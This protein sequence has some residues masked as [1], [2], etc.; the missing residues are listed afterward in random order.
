ML[1]CVFSVQ[2]DFS[3]EE[4]WFCDSE[5]EDCEEF[6]AY[7]DKLE[8]SCEGMWEAEDDEDL[9]EQITEKTNYCVFRIE[10]QNQ[11]PN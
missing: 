8:K 4:C 3:D 10:Y 2:L 5:N 6:A 7:R 11:L 1:Y 9:I